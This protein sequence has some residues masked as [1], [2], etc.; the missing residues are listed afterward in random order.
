MNR[1][2]LVGVVVALFFIAAPTTA[3]SDPCKNLK[4][5]P[6]MKCQAAQEAERALERLRRFRSLMTQEAV[7][8]VVE[9]SEAFEPYRPF[10]RHPSPNERPHEKIPSHPSEVAQSRK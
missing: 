1:M 7:D 4:N 2:T 5:V 3:N 9:V 10:Y 6:T 8:I